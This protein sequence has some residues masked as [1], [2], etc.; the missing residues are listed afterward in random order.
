MGTPT[1]TAGLTHGTLLRLAT[2]GSVDD[3]KS[4][5]VGRLLHD[6]KNVLSDQLAAVERV[7]RDRGLSAT[8]LALLTD[9]LRAEREQGITID[10]AYRYFATARRSYI[11]ADC[12]G[13][14]QYTR[15]TVT[16][17][18]TAD[19]VVLLTDARK[20][21]LEQ[22]RRHLAVAALLRV[23]H[24]IVAVN[25]IDLVDF[26][27]AVFGQV[28]RD[29]RAVA[30][31][32]GVEHVHAIPTSALT[33]DNIVEPSLNTPWYEGPSLLELLET[34]PVDAA[35][36]EPGFRFPVQLV[37]R[38][39]Q[40]ALDPALVDYRGYAGRLVAGRVV[41]GDEVIAEPSG[42][43][44]RVVGIDLGGRELSEARAPQ[45]VTLRLA[46]DIDIARGDTIVSPGL[47]A[48]PVKEVSAVL[49]WL[50]DESLASRGRYLVK[51]GSATVQAIVTSVDSRLDLDSLSDVPASGLGLNDIGRVHLR[52]AKPLP[53]S[54]YATSRPGGAFL[55]VDPASGGTLAAGMV[56]S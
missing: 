7:S 11:L 41:V 53:V 55:L 10:V 37:V 33:G 12:P 51:H 15:N 18:S 32:L 40:A 23:P 1:I 16:G 3:G 6:T 36:D 19:V 13:H 39:Q 2:A 48:E 25:K 28:S 5:L 56:T 20:G 34:L 30:T 52:L 50:S 49:C 24:V 42:R 38:P 21:V 44:S 17:S 43:R 8:D 35:G 54:D 9:G 46:D 31:G 4:T 45:S 27:Q 29:I 14:V 26:S 47:A 22:T